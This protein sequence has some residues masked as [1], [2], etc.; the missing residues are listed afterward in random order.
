MSHAKNNPERAWDKGLRNDDLVAFIRC[1]PQGDSWQPSNR[2]ILFRVGE[3]RATQ[4]LAGLSRMKAASEGSEIRLTWPAT[5]PKSAGQVTAVSPDRIET[6]LSS[7]RKQSYRVSRAQMDLVPYVKPGDSFGDGDTVIASVMP[8]PVASTLV[9]SS[10]Y[11][12]L[13]DLESDQVETVYI[14]VMAL[15]FLPRAKAESAEP[16]RKIM[17]T[18]EDK[19][20]SLEAAAS[21]CALVSTQAGSTWPKLSATRKYRRN[22]EWN[23]RSFLLSSHV[24]APLTC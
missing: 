21:L 20:V 7:G 16:L 9:G 22:T 15:G 4:E 1:S 2:V 17:E 5:V 18:H 12:F 24:H 13:A 11:D 10:R 8:S 14:A 19:R 23:R 6:Q 3:M